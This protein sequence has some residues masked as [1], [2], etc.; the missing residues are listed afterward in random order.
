MTELPIKGTHPIVL[1][2][3]RNLCLVRRIL[4]QVQCQATRARICGQCN[5]AGD[6]KLV[7]ARAKKVR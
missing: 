3:E 5:F 6:I 1:E 2:N 4:F 7:M